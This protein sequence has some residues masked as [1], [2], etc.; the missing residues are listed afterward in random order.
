MNLPLPTYTIGSSNRITQTISGPV[1]ADGNVMEGESVTLTC[2]VED[3]P[4]VQFKWRREQVGFVT[5]L[6]GTA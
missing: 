1:D 4:E 2:E 3:R 5:S 6:A